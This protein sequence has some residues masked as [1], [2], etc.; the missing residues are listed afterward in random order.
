[1]AGRENINQDKTEEIKKTKKEFIDLMQDIMADTYQAEAL[2]RGIQAL[3]DGLMDR[4]E[5]DPWEPI[6]ITNISLSLEDMIKTIGDKA[7]E[8][9]TFFHD[10]LKARPAP[11]M[12]AP[13]GRT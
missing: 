2:L 8:A 5:N 11:V 6:H 1:M 10:N 12:R 4:F 9:N 13:E 3:A 7:L